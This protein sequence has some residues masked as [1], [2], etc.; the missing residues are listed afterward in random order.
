MILAHAVKEQRPN[1]L[2]SSEANEKAKCCEVRPIKNVN[3]YNRLPPCNNNG[4]DDSANDREMETNE[5]KDELAINING[6]GNCLSEIGTVE[7]LWIVNDRQVEWRR[8]G[9]TVK[10]FTGEQIALQALWTRFIS[11]CVTTRS[12]LDCIVIREKGRLRVYSEGGREFLVALPFAVGCAWNTG[13]GLLLE[14][15]EDQNPTNTSSASYPVHANV[16]CGEYRIKPPSLM[17][18]HHPLDDLTRIIAKSG[19]AD[20][21]K[22]SEWTGSKH[23]ILFTSAN[24]SICV[25]FDT[26]TGY[27]NIWLI[28]QICD[29]DEFEENLV[30]TESTSENGNS[31][32]EVLQENNAQKTPQQ[33]L[34]FNQQQPNLISHL[35]SNTRF[36]QFQRKQFNSPTSGLPSASGSPSTLSSHASPNSAKPTPNVS[37]NSCVAQQ[38]KSHN[39]PNL[40]GAIGTSTRRHTPVTSGTRTSLMCTDSPMTFQNQRLQSEGSGYNL[41]TREFMAQQGT[42]IR[43][44][45]P[46][47]NSNIR[48]HS[49]HQHLQHGGTPRLSTTCHGRQ[50]HETHIT[51]QINSNVTTAEGNKFSSSRGFDFGGTDLPLAP[52]FSLCLDHLWSEEDQADAK[53]KM[54]EAF[55]IGNDNKQNSSTLRHAD[56]V[57]LSKDVIGNK[58]V[59]FLHKNKGVIN[60]LPYHEVKYNNSGITSTE[61]HQTTL[62]IG[63]LSQIGATQNQTGRLILDAAPIDN[64]GMIIT[65]EK[66]ENGVE[67]TEDVSDHHQNRTNICLY[68]GCANQNRSDNK[69]ADV[70]IVPIDAGFL[71]NGDLDNGGNSVSQLTQQI[72]NEISILH[73]DCQPE[74]LR[75]KSTLNDKRKID[76]D[77]KGIVTSSRPPS[78]NGLPLF[79]ESCLSTLSPVAKSDTDFPKLP[80]IESRSHT[81]LQA[82]ENEKRMH[83]KRS[84]VEYGAQ[85]HVKLFHNGL[86]LRLTLPSV[87]TSSMVL[88]CLKALYAY[89][90][91]SHSIRLAIHWYRMR[92]A[93]GPSSISASEEWKLF[94]ECLFSQMGYRIEKLK[95]DVFSNS[96][97]LCRSGNNDSSMSPIYPKKM[98]PDEAGSEEDWQHLLETRTHIKSGQR[99]SFLLGIPDVSKTVNS[100][101]LSVEGG[102]KGKQG[103]RIA[104][105]HETSIAAGTV[106]PNA[107]LFEHIGSI[108]W[109]L[110][111]LYEDFKL[112]KASLAYLFPMCKV[113]SKLA[114]DLKLVNYVEHYWKDFPLNCEKTIDLAQTGQML[115]KFL[116]VVSK[117]FMVTSS[118]SI[119]SVPQLNPPCVYSHLTRLIDNSDENSGV[120]CRFHILP[121]GAT[122]K[123]RDLIIIYAILSFQMKKKH[124]NAPLTFEDNLRISDYLEIS[125]AAGDLDIGKSISNFAKLIKTKNEGKQ[126]DARI[127]V[128]ASIVRYVVDNKYDTWEVLNSIPVV[129]ALP[130]LAALFEC[131]L[132]PRLTDSRQANEIYTLIGRPDL[133]NRCMKST[134]SIESDLKEDSSFAK[135][136]KSRDKN[137]GTFNSQQSLHRGALISVESKNGLN[138]GDNAHSNCIYDGLESVESEITRLRWPKD[139]RLADVRR[140]LQSA[141]PVIIAVEQRPEMSDHDFLEVQERALQSLC[142]RTMALSIGRGA[143]SFRTTDPLPTETLPIPKLCLSGRAPPRGATVEMDHIDVVPNMERWP[144]FHNGVAAGLR[145]AQEGSGASYVDSNWITFNKPKESSTNPNELVEHGGFL[146]ALGLNGQLASLG[147][148]ESFDYLIRGNDMISVGIL[149]GTC[150]AKRGSMDILATKKIAT[151]VEALLPSTATELPLS[152]TTQVAGLAGLGLL[153]QGTGHRQMAEICLSE[154]GRPPGPEMENCTDR[155]SYSLSAGLALGMITLGKGEMLNKG[156][157]SDLRLPE[158]LYHHMVGGTRNP[159]VY[160]HR[161]RSPSSYQIQEGDTIN[162]DITS[163]GATLALG[164]MFFNS[165]NKTYANWMNAP[166]SQFLLEFVRPDFLMVRTLAK[167]LILWDSILPNSTWIYSHVP[168]SIRPYCLRRPGDD[169]SAGQ[170]SLGRIRG[171]AVDYETINQAYCNIVA[172]AALAMGLRFAGSNNSQAFETLHRI[173]L[174]LLAISKRS[175]AELAGKATIEQTICVL[176]LSLAIVAAGSGDLEVIRIIR[177]L[178]SRV[179]PKN[180]TVTYGSHMA[181]HMA[182]GLLFLGG[183]KY[184][185][186]TSPEAVAAMVAA[187][188]PKFPTHSNDNRYHLQALRHL[189]VLAAEPRL[190]IPRD[191]HSG[192]MVFCHVEL[193][194]QDTIWYKGC[195]FKQKAPTFL[196][197]LKYL[198]KVSIKDPRYH[199]MVFNIK[200][201]GGFSSNDEDENN[202]AQLQALFNDCGGILDIQQKAGSLSYQDDPKG[203]RSLTGQC[204]TK[205]ASFQWSLSLHS[206]RLLSTFSIEPAVGTFTNLFIKQLP[207]LLLTI[208]GRHDILK[209]CAIEQIMGSILYECASQEK[210]DMLPFYLQMFQELWQIGRPNQL[211]LGKQMKLLVKLTS[212]EN[213]NCYNRLERGLVNRLVN[214][215][216]VASAYQGLQYQLDLFLKQYGTDMAKHFLATGKFDNKNR[217]PGTNSDDS[218]TEQNFENIQDSVVTPWSRNALASLLI[219]HQMMATDVKEIGDNVFNE[220]SRLTMNFRS[221]KNLLQNLLKEKHLM[222]DS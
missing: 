209:S 20:N 87:C 100:C 152:N 75:T 2:W 156:S 220:F 88:R 136:D 172:G 159:T 78:A 80:S 117:P 29:K 7:E 56:K 25:T 175:V 183:G 32:Y 84:R 12:V 74:T 157:L 37:T 43:N 206:S 197:E 129:L 193:E 178:R 186:S 51:E 118:S 207:S 141:R 28:R 13:Y 96:A 134:S 190:L 202:F 23:K 85:N 196:P 123:I 148:L 219:F 182:L 150:T 1:Y 86:R 215:E 11:V 144:S 91:N 71:K 181:L 54:Y 198:K 218:Q 149:L 140:M 55:Q 128:A 66:H 179:G 60:I 104:L 30:N 214:P 212:Q 112:D 125:N 3:I 67:Q 79:N 216:I 94:V 161:F 95:S 168:A 101:N 106:D 130:V 195:S 174:E 64:L 103:D 90:P 72:S 120:H 169:I 38:Q 221:K 39:S 138:A 165:G 162:I 108:L 176:V 52:D 63:N 217:V 155:E 69:V 35:L 124:K 126:N 119:C 154:L 82:S 73:L 89:L 180:P 9:N 48:K 27:H 201:E 139:R 191:I 46:N 14:R 164:L 151:Q 116:S 76:L 153:Y 42:P 146:M 170:D 102:L 68:T 107:N 192:R 115:P 137:E 15:S 83:A 5:L 61:E 4:P 213:T 65:L 160:R 147:K 163:P 204:L 203:F 6:R 184:S 114:G 127:D 99:L 133:A 222:R 34:P 70:H 131:R 8:G 33:H 132:N 210:L 97:T 81:K 93:P 10:I 208:D 105:Q 24:P 57:F 135:V 21:P 18:L 194:L 22:F 122:Q 98:R 59:C 205:D 177:L 47:I 62:V 110:H 143:L 185:L 19:T 40:Y 50:Q 189:Y 167:G 92:N 142:V 200:S 31:N 53:P 26:T 41:S 111:L 44:S 173:T 113:L 109:C 58:F 36:K 171:G 145:I 45:N 121:Y 16:G 77:K 158:T 211:L 199:E 49:H 17:V 166:D 188:F 187:F